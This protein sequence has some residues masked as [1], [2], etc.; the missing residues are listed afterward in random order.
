[1]VVYF[2]H[3]DVLVLEGKSYVKSS[4]AARDLG[5]TSD[6]VGQL[7]RSGKVDSK[8][9]GRTWYVVKDSIAGHKTTRYRSSKAI[10]KRVLHASLNDEAGSQIEVHDKNNQKSENAKQVHFYSRTQTN[11]HVATRYIHD[12]SNLI[13]LPNKSKNKQL[14]VGLADAEKVSITSPKEKYA[15]E[16]PTLPEI[17]FKGKL[18]VTNIEEDEGVGFSEV[19]QDPQT[20]IGEG[21]AKP[22]P[23]HFHPKEVDVFK[24]KKPKKIAISSVRQKHNIANHLLVTEVALGGTVLIHKPQV[25]LWYSVATY[26]I[27]ILFALFAGLLVSGLVL[28]LN[29]RVEYSE[30]AADSSLYFNASV[31]YDLKDTLG[32]MF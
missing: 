1:M 23:K 29:T 27:A 28:S 30:R 4:V 16:V 7:C 26:S 32:L 22:A 17:R 13:P 31:L 10:T 9:F 12:E 21:L 6:Y 20:E 25:A 3:M 11:D 15:F 18:S 19:K 14:L 2:A 8:L 5:Y 24:H